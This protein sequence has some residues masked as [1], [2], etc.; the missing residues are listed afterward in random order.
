MHTHYMKT[1][2]PDSTLYMTEPQLHLVPCL[3][4]AASTT[5][6]VDAATHHRIAYWEWNETGNPQHPHVVICLHGLSRQGRDFDVLARKLS[7]YMRVICP[8]MAGRG[9]S[10]WLADPLAYQ[11]PQYAA[12]MVQ[13]LAHLQHLSP[14]TTLDWVGTSMGGLIGMALCGQP[15]LSIP[16]VAAQVVSQEVKEKTRTLVGSHWPLSVP[17]RRFVINDVG[18]TLAFDALQRIGQ[19]I[20]Q[21][22]HFASLQEGADALWALSS[23]FGLHTP[24]QWLALSIPMLRPVNGGGYRLHYD[25]AIAT[26][27]QAITAEDTVR[28]EES[29]WRLYDCIQSKTLLLRGKNSDLLTSETAYAMT[30]RGPRP[31]CIEWPDIGHAPTLVSDDQVQV[32]YQFLRSM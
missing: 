2:K 11:V 18:P 6:F 27:F 1:N 29:L 13:V 14:I 10:D 17:V 7:P 31:Q 20:G 25:P 26:A 24:E 22:H 30:Q 4:S 21:P 32:V 16:D 5:E 3:G 8:D 9:Y 28:N 15:G 12:D 19:Y 23:T